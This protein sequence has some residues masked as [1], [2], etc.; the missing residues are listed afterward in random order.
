VPLAC[1]L[2]RDYAIGKDG[3][4]TVA[5]LVTIFRDEFG[6][7]DDVRPKLPVSNLTR[8]L[9]VSG[10]APLTLERL[11]R[12]YPLSSE[13]VSLLLDVF[14]QALLAAVSDVRRRGLYRE[15]R[16]RHEDSSIPQGRIV[17]S[18][19]VQRHASRGIDHRVT[20]SWFDR[21]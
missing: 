9:G 15:Y 20:T 1:F 12:D 3:P 2:Y 13:P 11:T 5:A 14:S 7:T 16:N 18:P 8:L 4:M 21:T 6:F 17:F 10:L 19:T